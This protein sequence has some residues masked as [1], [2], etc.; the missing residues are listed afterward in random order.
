MA[1]LLSAV[2]L[3]HSEVQNPIEGQMEPSKASTKPT[4]QLKRLM[5]GS[6]DGGPRG[7]GPGIGMAGPS[8]SP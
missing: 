7:G 2:C 3:S 6:P 8:S 5:A 1:L 4:K